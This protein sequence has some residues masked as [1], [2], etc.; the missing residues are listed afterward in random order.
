MKFDEFFETVNNQDDDYPNWWKVLTHFKKM[1]CSRDKNP[2]DFNTTQTDHLGQESK[3]TSLPSDMEHQN[4]SDAR[5]IILPS[6]NS[7]E[8][9]K[10]TLTNSDNPKSVQ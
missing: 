7:P 1:G 3:A 9:V 10:A 8:N 4:M 5:I 6:P 2:E